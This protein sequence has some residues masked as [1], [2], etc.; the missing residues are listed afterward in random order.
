MEPRF[1]N[2][3]E[4]PGVFI[5]EEL[6]ARGWSQRDL[7]F[8]LGTTEQTVN[9]LIKGK[10]G[11]SAEMAKALGDAFGTSA[12]V[13]AGLQKVHELR[14]A[15]DPDPDIRFRAQLQE[16]YPVREMIVRG[17]LP[18][19]D[20][21]LLALQMA[22][23]FEADNINDVPRVQFSGVAKRTS[24]DEDP[25]EQ[26]AWLFRVRQ[27]ARTLDV[28]TYSESLLRD[29]LSDLRSLMIDPEDVR[30]VPEILASCGVRLVVVEA[31]PG[32][33]IDG[34]CT[35][36][37]DSSPVIGLST[38]YDRMDNFWLV[39]VHE[40]EHVL[41]G[42]GKER[43]VLDEDIAAKSDA[44]D[45]SEE[46]RAAVEASLSFGFP[47]E[48]IRSFYARKAPYISERDVVGFSALMEVHP[49][50]VVGQIQFMKNDWRFLRK[51]LVKV[52][53]F[54]MDT[55]LFDGWGQTTQADL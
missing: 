25:P 5:R 16:M 2:F 24:Y 51:Y 8:I 50:I 34:V 32:S 26:I 7:A 47:R 55:V 43:G 28:R 18:E 21:S 41:R 46:E 10:S 13:W 36:L 31:L 33:K 49:A 37:D 17:W 30:H 4:P 38:F 35:W 9:K 20:Q 12:E 39:L 23:F 53:A 11:V 1:N 15:R 27:I 40:I 6:E 19:D 45:L 29:R 22:R 44:S 52:R 14:M 3:A 48:K 42:D 54:L